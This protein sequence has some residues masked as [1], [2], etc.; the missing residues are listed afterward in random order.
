M[1]LFLLLH[2]APASE[3]GSGISP[4][5]DEIDDT[6]VR[7]VRKEDQEILEFIISWTIGDL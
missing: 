6:F 5:E 4:G 2:G 3:V 1:S 7:F